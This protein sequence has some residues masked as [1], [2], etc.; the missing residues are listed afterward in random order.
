VIDPVRGPW[1][2]TYSGRCFYVADPRPEEVH[3]ADIAHAHSLDNRWAS[4]TRWSFVVGH[5][6]VLASFHGPEQGAL[7]RLLHDAPEAYLRDLSRWVKE[8]PR[9]AAYRELEKRIAEVI[10]ETFGLDPNFWV[11]D[12]TRHVDQAMAIT[13]RDKLFKQY[14]VDRKERLHFDFKPVIQPWS[15]IEAEVAFLVRF[16]ELTGRS[17]ELELR[18]A[19]EAF[20]ETGHMLGAHPARL[21]VEL[22]LLI[23]W[24]SRSADTRVAAEQARR[25]FWSMLGVETSGQM[26]DSIGP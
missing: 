15:H 18:G 24:A 7:D 9:F 23:A 10:A 2:P 14:P 6:C 8:D 12:S 3:I 5:H 20:D 4:H 1:I 25:S 26:K 22:A 21:M 13:E 19:L 16:G 17:V 11:S